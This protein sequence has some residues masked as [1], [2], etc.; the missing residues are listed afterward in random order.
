MQAV[1]QQVKIPGDQQQQTCPIQRRA[2]LVCRRRTALCDKHAQCEQHWQVDA[3]KAA[4][5]RAPS[6]GCAANP[7][8]RARCRSCHRAACPT[9]PTQKVAPAAACR[10]PAA[11]ALKPLARR[12]ARPSR[13][14]RRLAESPSGT[15]Q[16]TA[17]A[18]WVAATRAV[19]STSLRKKLVADALNIATS[20]PSTAYVVM[21]PRCR[22]QRL[23][24]AFRCT[25]DQRKGN[26]AA[27][28]GAMASAPSAPEW[29][30]SA[31]KRHRTIRWQRTTATLLA[32]SAKPCRQ[33]IRENGDDLFALDVLVSIE[34]HG[35]SAQ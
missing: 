15:A 7:P 6:N 29:R 20:A 10:R 4:M 12:D 19:C 30:T 18:G 13:P 17:A 14:A 22:G 35:N 21:R 31:G 26:R 28:G 27:H 34:N 33:A 5:T 9:T 2:V 8:D 1:R 3:P 16:K 23:S 32:T 24:Q 25:R 11:R